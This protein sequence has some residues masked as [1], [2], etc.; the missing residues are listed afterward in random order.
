MCTVDVNAVVITCC[1]LDPIRAHQ[2]A[3]N[4]TEFLAHACSPSNGLATTQSMDHMVRR[5][6]K[7]K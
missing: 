7:L 2:R 6:R 3:L 4:G 1:R 5:Q